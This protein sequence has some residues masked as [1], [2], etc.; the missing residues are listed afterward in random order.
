M[1]EGAPRRKDPPPPPPIGGS[2]AEGECSS[3]NNNALGEAAAAA[4]AVTAALP[5][6]SMSARIAAKRKSN[7]LVQRDDDDD[8]AAVPESSNCAN[9]TNNNNNSTVAA[10]RVCK[11][12]KSG[13]G[14]RHGSESTNA[15]PRRL[16][17]EQPHHQHSQGNDGGTSQNN[18]NYNNPNRRRSHQRDEPEEKKRGSSR[19]HPRQSEPQ[20]LPVVRGSSIRRSSSTSNSQSRNGERANT[21]NNNNNRN[22]RASSSCS[23]RNKNA[24]AKSKDDDDDN[25][26]A[27]AAAHAVVVGVEDAAATAA[28]AAAVECYYDP[29]HRVHPLVADH[30]CTS[31]HALLHTTHCLSFARPNAQS[32]HSAATLLGLNHVL[33]DEP[34]VQQP[35]QEP[36]QQ[37]EHSSSSNTIHN[38]NH[39]ESTVSKLSASTTGLVSVA[40]LL[41]RLRPDRTN[42]TNNFTNDI[43]NTKRNRN[44]D[45]AF[46][47]PKLGTAPDRIKF[48]GGSST[49]NND[50]VWLKQQQQQQQQLPWRN[51][52]AAAAASSRKNASSPP[53]SPLMMLDPRY[54]QLWRTPFIHTAR[55]PVTSVQQA[56][57]YQGVVAST[58]T[59]TKPWN[60]TVE[61]GM[62]ATVGVA[63]PTITT[64]SDLFERGTASFV[65]NV[66]PNTCQATK[67]STVQS[68]QQPWNNIALD[69][70]WQAYTDASTS[71]S[72]SNQEIDLSAKTMQRRR[73]RISFI[74]LDQ[75]RAL[76]HSIAVDSTT[77]TNGTKRPAPHGST[78]AFNNSDLVG[79]TAGFVAVINDNAMPCSSK[80]RS[81]SA[82]AM[83]T[84]GAPVASPQ[85]RRAIGSIVFQFEWYRGV[86]QAV[87]ES[88]LILHIREINTR[89]PAVALESKEPVDIISDEPQRMDLMDEDDLFWV[90]LMLVAVVLEQ[91]RACRVW[92]AMVPRCTV[93]EQNILYV[94]FGM[95]PTEMD[96]TT[97]ICDLNQTS[98]KLIFLRYQE[99]CNKRSFSTTVD[100][101]ISNLGSVPSKHVST[102]QRW[103]VHLPGVEEAKAAITP[104]VESD[105][106]ET[107]DS[108][109]SSL[110]TKASS[111]HTA[112]SWN[113]RVPLA[114]SFTGASKSKRD[115]KILFRAILDSKY[116]NAVE[117]RQRNMDGTVGPELCLPTLHHKTPSL[118][119]LKSFDLPAETQSHVELDNVDDD[120]LLQKL[121]F[122]QNALSDLEAK[123]EPVICSL[124]AN[125]VLERVEYE[126]EPSVSKRAAELRIMDGSRK[127]TE[128]RKERDVA[129]QQQLEKDMDAVCE[130]CVDGEV[131]PDNQILFCE[132]CNVAVHQMCYGIDQVPE[133]DYHCLACRRL[134][135]DKLHADG[136]SSVRDPLP[137]FCELCP[138]RQGAFILTKTTDDA[139]DRFVHVVCAK[140]MGLDYVDERRSEQIED[141]TSTKA[142]FR[143]HGIK[144][145]LCLGERGGMNQCSSNG[146]TK[147][148]HVTCGRAVGNMTV[149]H[150]ENCLGPVEDKPWKLFCPDHSDLKI[151]RKP[152][153][154]MT[155]ES[156]IRAAQS[157]PPE[158]KPPPIPRPFY[159]L[160]CQ[161]QKELLADP[162]YERT[163]INAILHKKNRGVRCDVCDVVDEDIKNLTR[164]LVCNVV[165]CSSCKTD[166]DDIK[167]SGNYK[168][169]SCVFIESNQKAEQSFETPQCSCC[170]QQ[171]G[172][173]REAKATP[174]NLAKW[175]KKPQQLKMS[176]FG[177]P[178]W[179]HSLCAW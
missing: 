121:V 171:G 80:P 145:E 49:S 118:S 31:L 67:P 137:I 69:A 174:I 25:T 101:T 177:K 61:R 169:Q 2:R 102:K 6:F 43:N 140:W 82:E 35:Q 98:S 100:S 39:P 84:Y 77:T 176:M 138:T 95:I 1:S 104:P 30:D 57:L 89:Q 87:E 8:R 55:V 131:T 173:L 60:F 165:F 29:N 160:S 93:F 13:S 175:K 148:Y 123:L 143:R 150:G 26:T 168:C 135:R 114:V 159:Q 122:Q 153:N 151:N 90:R 128:F 12:K 68:Q 50:I 111:L 18:T 27:P 46:A 20:Q 161:D 108:T 157:F 63:T 51:S 134:G 59:T 110:A 119:I 3:S 127:L 99:E 85:Q 76:L 103:L 113:H 130:I 48:W 178:I 22:S 19:H 24:T 75:A 47:V 170:G 62:S 32:I 112:D 96:S 155:K 141:V 66:L 163:L 106:L 56:K 126:S 109:F 11:R 78:D 86:D 37:P 107:K 9:G 15:P 4:A 154:V 44:R 142:E 136:V 70:A 92:Y 147:F 33:C 54:V 149:I 152:A 88:E 34:A 164:C 42:L 120:E 71:L 10:E 21:T 124:L 73:D 83:T 133:G 14:A 52:T 179:V 105:A 146:C 139:V 16:Q 91:A 40:Q 144:C 65:P 162:E 117:L 64:G 58:T 72:V 7:S 45:S 28:A 116:P 167:G 17:Q 41:S 79:I 129:W 115:T 53:P 97:M 158:P 172:L 5:P 74:P 156:L 81:Q 23:R 38:G 166:V 94:Y 132:T 36:P 125:V